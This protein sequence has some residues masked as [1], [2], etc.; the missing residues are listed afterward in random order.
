MIWRAY[1]LAIGAAVSCLGYG[2]GLGRLLGIAVDVGDAGI[3]GLTCIAILGCAIHFVSALSTPVQ[4][5]TLGA[6]L[7]LCL[8]FRDELIRRCRGN[9]VSILVGLSVFFHRHAFTFYDNGFYH[10]QSIKWNSEFPITPGLVNLHMRLAYNSV[11]FI[12]APLDDR[13]EFGWISN[14]LVLLFVLASCYARFSQARR[15]TVEFWFFG[16]AVA[17]LALG[18]LGPLAWLGVWNADGFVA[19]LTVYWFSVALSLP[20]RPPTNVPLLL[21]AG[22]LALTVKLS[23]A[24]LFLL[25]LLAAWLHR[26]TAG[27]SLLKPLA[28]AAVLLGLWMARGVTLS[29]CAVYPV[30]Q[31]CIPGLPWAVS[32]TEAE[33]ET[34]SIRSWA[35]APW[36]FDYSKVMAD[37]TWLG[38]WTAAAWR[39]WSARLFLLGGIAGCVTM[40]AGLRMNRMVTA[41][42]AGLCFCLAYWFLSAPDVRFGS[43]YLAAAGILGLSFACAAYFPDTDLMRRLTLDAVAVSVLLGTAALVQSGNTWT[44]QNRPAFAMM[45]APGGKSIW[46]TVGDYPGSK[47]CWD[48]PLPCSPYFDPEKLKRIRWR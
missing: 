13:A 25:A 42:F 26:K 5:V 33:M 16:L 38:Q 7:E 2:F 20:S 11:L 45:T 46:V 18:T 14:L 27:V 21:L 23:A 30:P 3:L 9:S 17:L 24:P 34:L 43:G 44:I 1:A 37:W 32:R 41:A 19:I 29:G 10:L 35:R 12:L 47:H 40:L 28:V 4:M 6:G 22:V 48:H 36:H 8:V 31:S 39:D 15:A